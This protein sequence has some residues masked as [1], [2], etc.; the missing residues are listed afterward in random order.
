MTKY[1][2]ISCEHAPEE[3]KDNYGIRSGNTL[4][5]AV[6]NL[7]SAVRDETIK[8]VPENAVIYTYLRQSGEYE[9]ALAPAPP[10]CPNRKRRS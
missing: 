10:S 2:V 4:E 9:A 7:V 8:H 6:E 5:K 3:V 1:K